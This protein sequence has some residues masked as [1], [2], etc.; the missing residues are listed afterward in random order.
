MEEGPGLLASTRV[1]GI[2]ELGEAGAPW[3]LSDH[4]AQGLCLNIPE[5][6]LKVNGNRR[7]RSAVGGKENEVPDKESAEPQR[8]RC[9][10]VWDVP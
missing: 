7:P 5:S 10:D 9:G 4:S 6:V 8:W 1:G 3:L 2:Q